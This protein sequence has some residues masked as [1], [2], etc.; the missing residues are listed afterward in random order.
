MAIVIGKMRFSTTEF[1]EKLSF[2]PL[3]FHIC[4]A[5]PLRTTSALLEGTSLFLFRSGRDVVVFAGDTLF[6]KDFDLQ[7]SLQIGLGWV[8]HAQEPFLVWDFHHAQ[9]VMVGLYRFIAWGEPQMNRIAIDAVFGQ[10]FFPK[11]GDDTTWG[12]PKWVH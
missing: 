4:G 12:D 10:F 9:E 2:S 3:T 5:R 7:R 8:F 6:F 1:P 11:Y